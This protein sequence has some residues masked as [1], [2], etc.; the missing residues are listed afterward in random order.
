[1]VLLRHNVENLNR[2]INLQT[3]PGSALNNAVILTFYLLITGLMHVGPAW[4]YLTT[5]V[6]TV[7]AVFHL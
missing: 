4:M 3:H 5:L 7:E 6:L 2:H 1:M